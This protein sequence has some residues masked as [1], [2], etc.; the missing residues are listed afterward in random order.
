MPKLTID[1]PTSHGV[2]DTY[3]KLKDFFEK[4]DEIKKYDPKVQCLFNDSNR[5][6]DLKGSQ[7]KGDFKVA[8]AAQGSQVTINIDLPFLLSPLKGKIEETLLK[9]LKKHV[10]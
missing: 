1:Y 7:F 4:T 10:G 6:C 9:M 2:T 5:T 3:T 8:E